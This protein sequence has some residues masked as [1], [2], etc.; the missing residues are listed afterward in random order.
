LPTSSTLE[1]LRI[2]TFRLLW[3]ASIVSNFGG[4]IQGVGAA[5][6]MTTISDSAA[7]VAL[8]QGS[9]TLPVMLF[10]LMS[11]AVADSFDRRRV[12]LI[13]Q[14]FMAMVAATLAVFAWLGLLTPWLLLTFTFLMGCGVAFNNP[15][16]QASVGDIVPREQLTS[17]VLLNSVSFNVTRSVGPALGGAIVAAAGAAAAFAV[18]A[19]SYIGL[20]A[21]IWRWR[22]ERV[23]SSLPREALRAAMGTGVRYVA[24]SPNIVRIL[25]RGFVFGMTTIVLLALLPLVA[26]HLVA[27]DALTYGILLGAFGVGAVFGAGVSRP[28]RE[29][30]SNEVLVR[31]TFVAFAI[32]AVT[33]AISSNLRITA[34]ALILGGGAWVIT[35]SLFNTTVQLSTPRWVV[36]RA[37]S[38]YQMAIFGGM[39]SGSWLWGTIA[40]ATSPAISLIVAAFGMLL[41]ALIGVRVPL[42]SNEVLNLDPLNRWRE[43]SVAVPIEPR[44]GPI[45]IAVEYQ[46]NEADQQAFHQVMLERRRI[47]RRDGAHD[48]V[49]SQDLANPR[50]WI[51]RFDVPTWL[52]YVRFHSRTT[53]ADAQVSDRIETLHQGEGAPRVTRMLEWKGRAVRLNQGPTGDPLIV[54]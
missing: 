8:V 23:P 16:W 49:L 27:G 13:A 7:M 2:K 17:A 39:A 33:T 29:R 42:L 36:G 4:L 52:D 38:L 47:R 53:Q 30:V 6:M 26:R 24:L 20:I 31:S 5:W 19:I 12:M 50:L 44:S 22:P 18:N 25:M 51:E 21:V 37:L 48:W 9:T 14:I 41:G 1:P 54:P 10:S 35:L 43:P 45:A 40:E 15:A 3:L 46:I 34:S 28:L 32:V 11:G